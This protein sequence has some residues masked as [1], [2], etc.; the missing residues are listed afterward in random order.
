MQRFN[1]GTIIQLIGPYLRQQR[2]NILLLLVIGMAHSIATILIPLSLGK[3][4]ELVFHAHS[5]RSNILHLAGISAGHNLQEF[6]LFFAAIIAIKGIT[7]W[8]DHYLTARQGE[9][10][11]QALR[12]NLF[13][14]QLHTRPAD[15]HRKPVNK[16]LLRYS[17]DMKSLRRLYTTG[18]LVF[19]RDVL[20][21][22]LSLYLLFMIQ[23]TLTGIILIALLLFYGVNFFLNKPLKRHNRVKRDIQSN[24]LAFTAERLQAFIAVKA[25]HKEAIEI[26][27]FSKYNGNLYTNSC[28]YYRYNTLI[29]ALAPVWLY[30]LLLAILVLIAG[31][32]YQMGMHGGSTFTFIL[33]FMMLFPT[34]RRLI[35][36]ESVWQ[37]GHTTA[38]KMLDL[39]RLP[40][41]GTDG[42]VLNPP[43]NEIAFREVMFSYRDDQVLLR[44]FNKQIK[45]GA[46]NYLDGD[47]RTT[48]MKLLMN[49]Y[50]PQKGSIT[51][52][53]KDLQAYN[54]ASIREKM[55]IV[56]EEVPLYGR[57]I[58]EALA[59]GKKR[60]VRARI[61]KM[62]QELHFDMPFTEADIDRDIGVNGRLLSHRQRKVLLLA[63]AAL[64]NKPVWLLDRPFSGLDMATRG[65]LAAWLGKILQGKTVIVADA[66]VFA[67]SGFLLPAP[68]NST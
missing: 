68:P 12:A 28:R 47:G 56:S 10:L 62:L 66:D 6:F 51:I 5:G 60:S 58:Y 21:M 16:Y 23:A 24:L 22:A 11:C 38:R 49:L 32:S 8:A 42:L 46:V 34:L 65:H 39:L 55:A 50:Q 15:F 37:T 14:T 2:K 48:V 59:P 20:F 27:R 57:S 7:G 29:Q 41:E 9:R 4:F 52:N 43:F 25:L 13:T 40:Q 54:V 36:V 63:R 26:K 44:H 17:G 35:R 64:M 33:L 3:Y 61:V 31:N 30:L 1:M 45:P 18:M 19:S 67:P 53:G